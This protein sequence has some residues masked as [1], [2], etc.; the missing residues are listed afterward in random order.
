LYFFP[1]TVSHKHISGKG[2]GAVLEHAR[3]MTDSG[4]RGWERRVWEE[5]TGAGAALEAYEWNK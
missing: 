5:M 3:R 2:I 4:A 1:H